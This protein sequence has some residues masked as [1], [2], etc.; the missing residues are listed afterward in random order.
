MLKFA[1]RSQLEVGRWEIE[2]AGLLHRTEFSS[3]KT[4]FA[5]FGPALKV[6]GK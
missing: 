4:R 1:K 6:E 2:P 5:I 3:R